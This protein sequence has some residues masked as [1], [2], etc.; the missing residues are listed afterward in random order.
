MDAKELHDWFAGPSP[1]SGMDAEDKQTIL[2]ALSLLA[3]AEASDGTT[4]ETDAE[5]FDDDNPYGVNLQVVPADFARRLES[6]R[7]GLARA[8]TAER[9]SADRNQ[10][11]AERLDWMDKSAFTAYRDRDPEYGE[12]YDFATVVNEDRKGDRVGEVF[13]TIRE[14]IDAARRK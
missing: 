3:A 9:E 4:P 1:V 6:E 13:K 5:A 10:E 14:A 2:R 8:L 12:L 11:D 7:N